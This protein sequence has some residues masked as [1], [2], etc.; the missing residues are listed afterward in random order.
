MDCNRC[1]LVDIPVSGLSMGPMPDFKG[2]TKTWLS[3]Y[4]ASEEERHAQLLNEV[5]EVRENIEAA[6]RAAV[7]RRSTARL[8]YED[9]RASAQMLTQRHGEFSIRQLQR[10]CDI[11]YKSAANYISRMVKEN[12]PIV[13]LVAIRDNPETGMPQ[14]R[15]AFIKP[16]PK[17]A[18]RPKRKPVERE[19]VAAH[20]TAVQRPSSAP[21]GQVRIK[22]GNPLM[23]ELLKSARDQGARTFGRLAGRAIGVFPLADVRSPDLPIT[24][25]TLL[26]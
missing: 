3:A 6:K 19:A 7:A 12:P 23:T 20:G 15:Y 21:T 25:T 8:S 17:P 4:I 22:T 18:P 16:E 26:L 10:A 11:S 9:I 5:S 24:L 14:H 13:K 2:K 1:H